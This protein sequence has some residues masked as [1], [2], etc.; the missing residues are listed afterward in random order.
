MTSCVTQSMILHTNAVFTELGFAQGG[1]FVEPTKSPAKSY[2][3][4]QN[5]MNG[6]AI[7]TKHQQKAQQLPTPVSD[8]LTTR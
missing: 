3:W 2:T 1:P 6:R 7:G 8:R 4:Y 5:Q